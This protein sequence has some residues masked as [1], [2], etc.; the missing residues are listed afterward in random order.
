MSLAGTLCTMCRASRQC[1]SI[2][3][4]SN[5][6]AEDSQAC[7][8][9]IELVAQSGHNSSN[10]LL[11]ALDQALQMQFEGSWPMCSSGQGFAFGVDLATPVCEC[12]DVALTASDNIDLCGADIAL[13][14]QSVLFGVMCVLMYQ[15]IVLVAQLAQATGLNASTVMTSDLSASSAQGTALRF[16][17]AEL[18]MPRI[19]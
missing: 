15:T 11:A 9:F 14:S 19:T 4:A 13:E 6:P 10:P 1:K 16:G 17:G 7:K 5:E 2:F 18:R 8:I 12:R 3:A